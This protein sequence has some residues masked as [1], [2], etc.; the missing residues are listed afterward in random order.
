MWTWANDLRRA[1]WGHQWVT[2]GLVCLFTAFVL[3]AG[4]TAVYKEVERERS[5]AAQSAVRTSE[6]RAVSLE[7]Y[8]ARTLETADLVTRHVADKYLRPGPHQLDLSGRSPILIEDEVLKGRTFGPITVVNTRGDLL[9]T[10]VAG[11]NRRVNVSDN[12]VFRAQQEQQ[13]KELLVHP[14]SRSKF[15][16]GAYIFLT[17]RV[18]DREG[19]TFGFVAVQIKPEEL[20]NFIK[21]ATFRPADMISV[22]GLDGITR[23]R[24][25]GNLLSF[26]EDLRGKLVMKMQ[27]RNP[28]GSYLGPSSLDGRIRYFTH[29]RIKDYP[30]FVTAGVSR[31][32]ALSPAAKRAGIYIASMAIVSL[33]SLLAAYLIILG[34]N[35]RQGRSRALA[36]ANARL[37]QA[38]RIAKVGDWEYDPRTG[39]MLWSDQLSQMYE[40]GEDADRLTLEEFRD[41]LDAEGR[42]TVDRAIDLALRTGEPQTYEYKAYLPSRTVSDRRAIAVPVRAEGGEIRS[43]LGTDQDV[44]S[45][46]LLKS[47]QEQVAHFGR[48]DAMNTMAS[49]LAHELN[50]PLTAAS[51]YLAAA[52]RLLGKEHEAARS[53]TM[54]AV[55][56]AKRQVLGAGEI[57]RRVREML[58]S[59]GRTVELVLLSEVIDEAVSLLVATGTC[60]ARCVRRYTGPDA[61]LVF[62]DKVQLQQV[63]INLVRNACEAASALPDPDVRVSTCRAG[64]RGRVVVSV[65]D[66]GQGIEGDVDQLFTPFQS[67]KE[68]GLGLGL[69][70]SRTIVEHHGGKIW[71]ENTGKSGTTISFS[72]R[73]GLEKPAGAVAV[74][75]A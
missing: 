58:K 57:I 33:V 22:I 53:R 66:N 19:S 54:E 20:S 51:N 67:S 52:E 50:Q 42:E 24:R 65:S 41:Y 43:L 70:I 44:T 1:S 36:I 64:D 8:V 56:L 45:A 46:R 37:R 63:L 17:R 3:V 61:D 27:A 71:V 35:Q 10:T 62:G 21:G 72:I 26:G 38:Q 5:E 23:A 40:R 31:D 15:L 75:S 14:P 29:R 28:N 34:I 7:Q 48:V 47:L 68:D 13:G 4:W 59:Y 74:Q 55:S 9:G 49:T 12:P 11:V 25:E 16:P 32:D 69:S 18:V 60:S 2:K 73:G 6:N 39:Q 30:I